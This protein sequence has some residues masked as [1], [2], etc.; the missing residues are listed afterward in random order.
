MKPAP[1]ASGLVYGMGK[2]GAF[3]DHFQEVA[4]EFYQEV[5]LWVQ[6]VVSRATKVRSI[7]NLQSTVRELGMNSEIPTLVEVDK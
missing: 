6:W 5:I 2:L 3:E 4:K 7:H 1:M